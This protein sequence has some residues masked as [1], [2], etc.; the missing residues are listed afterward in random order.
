M[1]F[2]WSGSIFEWLQNCTRPYILK[3]LIDIALYGAQCRNL[4]MLCMFLDVITYQR[5]L[6]LFGTTLVFISFNSPLKEL[7][8]DIKISTKKH[9]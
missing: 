2:I 1:I 3:M 4:S 8:N 5:Q 6:I 9:G 7:Q